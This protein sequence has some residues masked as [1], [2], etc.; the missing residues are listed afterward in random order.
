M[1]F[2]GDPVAWLKDKLGWE[3]FPYEADL[4]RCKARFRAVLKARQVG[5]TE[6]FAYEA[7]MRAFTQPNRTI[8]I[9]S[10]GDRQSKIFMQR[11]QDGIA[12]NRDLHALVKRMNTSGLWLKNGS[13]IL[14]LPDNPNRIRGFSA[15]SIYLD[16]AAMFLNDEEVAAAVRPMLAATSGDFTVVSTPR[17]KRGL[18]YQQ[19]QVAVQGQAKDNASM[20]AF[21]LYP[22]WINPLV[23]REK[24]EEERMFL[25]DWQWKQE[26]Q[27]EFIEQQ[28]TYLPLPLI[29]GCVDEG[30]RL[31]DSGV[32]GNEYILGVD[33]AKQRDETVV[34]I[35]ERLPDGMLVVR[36]I[37]AWA[38]MD[39]TEQIGR[40]KQLSELFLISRGAADATGV[41]IAVMEEVNRILSCV[42]GVTFTME[43]KADMASIL[44]LLLEQKNLKLPN[45]RRLIMQLNG[46]T[47]NVSKSG[48]YLFESPEKQKLHDDYLWALAL[49]C[50]A[51][52]TPASAYRPGDVPYMRLVDSRPRN[53]DDSYQ[54][55]VFPAGVY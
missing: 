12:L 36:H 53:D 7:L 38:G 17:G 13:M 2:S 24:I 28:D 51:A 10:P 11:I 31:L 22:S 55:V 19:Y 23:D 41:G 35:L 25:T 50:Y 3:A 16:E 15:T 52:R 37:Q 45:D 49:A 33:F 5:C 6:T 18:F 26:Y 39:Y 14:S 9:V 40:I 32:E 4:L 27:G 46:L 47:Y 44:R 34:V 42:E 54:R 21:D 30:L 1:Q 48:N 29:M 20:R 43:R 8:L